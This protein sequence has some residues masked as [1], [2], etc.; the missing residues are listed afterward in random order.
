M[1]HLGD[2]CEINGSKIP[3]VDVICGGSPCQN[4]SDGGN[5][6]G[7]GGTESSLFFEMVRVIKEMREHGELRANEPVRPR[8]CV[9]ENVP[10]V[11]KTHGGADFARIIEQ[12]IS[13]AERDACVRVRVPRNGWSGAGCFYSDDGRWSL[14]WRVHNPVFWGIPQARRRVAIVVDYGGLAAADVI[15]E[16]ERLQGDNL[17]GGEARGDAPERD[18]STLAFSSNCFGGWKRADVAAPMRATCGDYGGGSETLI[19]QD[20]RLRRWT[21]VEAERLQGFPDGWTDVGD[22]TDSKGRTRHTSNSAR[23]VALGNSLCLPFWH[24]LLRRIS[25]QY[26]GVPTLGSL[27]DGIGGFPLV[28]TRCNGYGSVIWNSEI[29]EFCEAVTTKHFGDDLRGVPGDVRDYL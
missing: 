3:P 22:W 15:F 9:F 4:F 10:G 14:A 13:I 12:Y 8:F 28:W 17:P 11:L 6:E 2:I 23:Y 18:D 26:V 7:L 25:A 21:P 20:G 5:R 1:I 16:R 24:W 19:V 29:S 27:F